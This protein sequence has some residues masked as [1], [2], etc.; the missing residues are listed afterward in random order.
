MTGRCEN[1][2]RIPRKKNGWSMYKQL[3]CSEKKKP[4]RCEIK[5]S[6]LFLEKRMA[7]CCKINRSNLRKKKTG[8]CEIN[9]CILRKK[10]DWSLKN[11]LKYLEKKLTGRCKNNRSISKK[12]LLVAVKLI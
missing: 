5:R 12:E 8:C 11:K 1:N 2:K 9:R 6:I 10:N 4:G 3:K 7:N